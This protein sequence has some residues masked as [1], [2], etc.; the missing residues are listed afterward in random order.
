MPLSYYLEKYFNKQKNEKFIYPDTWGSIILRN[1]AWIKLKNY[2]SLVKTEN[3][4]IFAENVLKEQI[5]DRYSKGLDKYD[6]DWM[7]FYE[8]VHRVIKNYLDEEE[9][10]EK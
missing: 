3:G 2:L 4:S 6:M 5:K 7:R 10:I 8:D 9:T 1:E